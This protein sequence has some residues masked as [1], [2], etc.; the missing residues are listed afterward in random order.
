[1]DSQASKSKGGV[2]IIGAGHAGGRAAERLRH[3]G[4]DK[5]ITLIGR[6]APAPYERPPLSKG[7]LLQPDS[8][9][10]ISLLENDW[11]EQNNIEL[12]TDT[13]VEK[14]DLDARYVRRSECADLPFQKLIIATGGRVR[15]INVPGADLENVFFLRTI[16]DALALRNALKEKTRLVVI[17]GGFIGLE[18]AASARTLGADVT[19][20]EATSQLMGRA[21][22]QVVG[23]MF[24]DIHTQNGVKIVLG[25][26]V[27]RII[28]KGI[29]E[30]VVL[31]N[32]DTIPADVVVV[33]I[34]ILPETEL[35]EQAGLDVNNGIL[36]DRFCQTSAADVFA[37][38][39][40][41]CQTDDATGHRFRLESWQNAEI[42]AACAAARIVGQDP[43]E[44][45]AS[46]FWSDQ[47]DIN[48]QIVGRPP[49]WKDLL[50]RGTPHDG[51]LMMFKVEG[52]RVLGAIG[53][54][55]KRD[56]MLMRKLMAADKPFNTEA[57]LNPETQLKKLV[58][59]ALKA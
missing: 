16:K 59:N 57:L 56:M 9:A 35:A 30:S 48:L 21:T 53:I 31:D 45:D 3:Y 41:T 28:G 17:G 58:L 40:V 19:I 52:G 5:K 36:V 27:E 54:N 38:G 55:A 20:V 1:V 51:P 37:I 11:Y 47:Y 22:P 50:V 25:H 4:Y 13:T 43:P 2:V 32:G 12:L 8:E 24:H 34:G 26:G 46:W 42:Q 18:V 49:D 29:V 33:G 39:D 23:D 15:R 6:E 7:V 14:I 44:K 10:E